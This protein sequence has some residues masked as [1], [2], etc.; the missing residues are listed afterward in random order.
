MKK[1]FEP[2]SIAIIGASERIE[3]VGH[4]VLRNVINSGFSGEIY[5]VNHKCG[6]I[7]SHPA[8]ASLNEIADEID[9]AVIA[10]PAATVPGIMW[11]CVNK[12]IR[13]VI[14]ITA[15]FSELGAEGKA[16][17]DEI[18]YIANAHDIRFIGSNCLGVIRPGKK[19]DAT[20]GNGKVKDG[21]MAI[22]SQSGAIITGVLDWA[23]TED[24]G[25]S[26]VVSLGNSDNVDFGDL[27]EFIAT[28]EKTQSAFLY[29]ESIKSGDK[30][31]AGLKA[32]ADQNKPVIII[33]SGHS[34]AG[35]K[36]AQ[37]HTAS[38]VSNDKIFNA[39]I[40][41][42]GITRIE[43]SAD[44][45]TAIKI[46]SKG[47]APIENKR[48]V[49][50]TNAGGPGV[51]ST[52]RTEKVGVQ[53]TEISPV[54]I[55]ALN[56]RLSPNWSRSNPVDLV[57]AATSIDY[58]K[59][60]EV[61]IHSD[62]ADGILAI[63]TPQSG[64]DV[65]NIARVL[66]KYSNLTAMPI[67]ASFIGGN[68]VQAG[69]ELFKGTNV[70]HF[71][72]PEQAVDA[73]SFL[74]VVTK[75]QEPEITDPGVPLFIDESL[76]GTV[77]D[78]ASSKEI[79]EA[80]DIPVTKTVVV[81]S[82]MQAY[83]ESAKLNFPVVLKI[84]MPEFSHKSDIGGVILNIESSAQAEFAYT[85]LDEAVHALQ[86]ELKNIVCTVEPMFKSKNGRELMIGVVRDPV[87]GA[88]ISFGLGGTMVEV[89]QD[90][91]I[92]LAPLTIAKAEKLIA[93]TK[94]AKYIAKFRNLPEAN[95]QALI[96]VLLKVSKLVTDN[97]A[98]QE[99]DINP[100]ILDENMAIALDARIKL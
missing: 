90:N 23:A 97:P 6:F 58:E 22:L 1:F 38:M 70:C 64:T 66:I 57:G 41:I 74:P 94:A 18:N 67:M 85:Q 65:E 96:N 26:T 37:S 45:F 59:A 9:L 17:Q 28:D 19:L 100:L 56:S 95:K 10:T 55:E 60:L 69:R 86:P 84:N 40:S 44:I 36:A 92:A 62:N 3:S 75:S 32:C 68:R 79:L 15:G 76:I 25:F 72:T 27:L 98:I 93:S 33:K 51:M 88:A 24:I 39:A 30:F 91:A 29:I 54:L 49:I 99:L 78:T 7:L 43:S 80:Y 52:D 48:L 16:L 47:H 31:I 89:L 61:L 5:P 82:A 14:I 87:F 50:M 11:Q 46:L 81:R 13:N 77:L 20:F 42:P 4:Q 35:S 34:K 8:Y 63:V 53:L 83:L 21:S 12:E 2:K 71:D 73:F